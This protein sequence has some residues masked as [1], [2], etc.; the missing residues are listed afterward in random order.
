MRQ[1]RLAK[2]AAVPSPTG[3]IARLISMRREPISKWVKGLLPLIEQ[4]G[5]ESTG[6]ALSWL[7]RQ[8]ALAR[9]GRLSSSRSPTDRRPGARAYDVTDTSTAIPMKAS[10]EPIK[11]PDTGMACR[12]SRATATGIKLKPPT[13]RLVGSKVIQ[14]VPGT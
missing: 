11:L 4:A 9:T 13:L 14:P 1:A 2:Y 5:I 7:V 3:R 10:P 12:I 8:V 6:K